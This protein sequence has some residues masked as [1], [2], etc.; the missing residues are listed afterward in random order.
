MNLLFLRQHKKFSAQAVVEFALVLPILL[1]L[2]YGMIEI[3]RLVFVFASVAN[4]SRQAARYGSA[5][6]EINNS[7]YYY[8]DCDGIRKVANQSSYIIKIEDVKITYDRGLYPDGTQ[9]PITGIDPNPAVDSCPVEY[10]TIRNGDR[11]I[12]QVSADYK[13]IIP[14]IPIEPI[15]IVS[16]SARSFLISIP[17]FGSAMPTGFA[18]ES[19]TPSK[20]PTLYNTTFTPT[21]AFTVTF[22]HIP[23]SGQINTPN[24]HLSPTNTL[25]ATVTFTP[26]RTPLPTNTPSITPTQISCTGLTGVSHG[27]LTFKDNVMEMSINN[28]SGYTLSTSQIYLE[29]NHDTGHANGGDLSLRLRQIIFAEQIWNGDIEAPSTYIPGYYPSIPP[30]E[31]KIQFVFHQN[32][33]HRDG[34]ERIIIYIGTP[35]C[36]NDPVDSS[37]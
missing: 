25:P 19:S 21:T 36:T 17:I 13:P 37:N 14:I 20:I 32:Y 15:K 8:Q 11:I 2:L 31:S 33:D 7:T 23:S 9:I 24:P 29:W 1:L 22:T 6:G 12:V 16:A 3:G 26:S 10:D 27:P 5:S 34:T 28:L 35:G 30:G 18:A 4:A